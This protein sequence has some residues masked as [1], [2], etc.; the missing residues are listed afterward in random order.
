MLFHAFLFQLQQKVLRI[1]SRKKVKRRW[2]PY[3]EVLY[4]LLN[5]M[6]V[7][8]GRGK[9]NV[10]AKKIQT[11]NIILQ[12]RWTQL[13]QRQME[14]AVYLASI[15]STCSYCLCHLLLKKTS[16]SSD[17]I[18]VN[19]HV[20]VFLLQVINGG[21]KFAY[22]TEAYCI[23]VPVAS[24]VQV[25]PCVQSWRPNDWSWW[26]WNTSSHQN[27]MWQSSMQKGTNLV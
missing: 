10:Q 17:K 20:H 13:K 5:Q 16:C 25:L 14:K 11:L 2:T 19:W 27:Y 24:L 21:N 6:S 15:I 9:E 1:G 22:R 26:Y 18:N 4:A 7:M 12:Q 23:F 8:S 3:L